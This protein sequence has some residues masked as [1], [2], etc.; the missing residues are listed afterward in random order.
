MKSTKFYQEHSVLRIFL[1]YFKAHR[2]LFALDMACALLVS[3]IDVAFPLVTRR[4][5][6]DLLPNGLYRAFFIVLAVLVAAF[7]L[8]AGLYYIVTYWGHLF[9]VRVEADIRGD[10]FHQMQRLGFDFYD[11]SRTGQLMS[12]LTTDLFD[13]TELAHHGPE[14]LLISFVTIGGALIAMFCICWQ[15]ALVVAIVLPLFLGILMHERGRMMRVSAEVKAR[16]AEIN[17][18]IESSLSGIRTARAFA[19]EHLESEKFTAGNRKYVQ[20]RGQFY[21][22]MG[23]FMTAMECLASVLM[24]AVIGA[25]GFLIM[26]GK[27]DLVDL[28]TF[29][30]FITA[31]INPVRKLA[32]LSELFAAGFAGLKRFAEVMRMEPS[33]RDKEDAAALEN[34]RGEIEARDVCFSYHPDE[35][36]LRDLSFRAAPGEH[37]GIVGLSGGGKSTLCQLILRF[38]DV[39]SGAILVDGRDVR[40]ITQDSLH[41]AVGIVQQDVFLFASTVGDNIRYGRPDATDAEVMEAAK[42]AEIFD[43]IDQMPQGFDTYVGE[44]GVRLSGGQKQRIA[45]ARMFLKN[46]AVLILDEAT[47]ALDSLTEAKVQAA[48]RALSQGRTT[49]TI[50]HRLSTIRDCDRIIVIQDGRIAETGSHEELLEKGGVYAGLYRMQES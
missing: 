4:V 41:R 19:N 20:A 22:A 37:I 11:S 9:G 10:L 17:E 16:T 24:V 38:Y 25:G 14:N 7:V 34:V 40:D 5:L 28:L 26:R 35:P 33:I 27:L 23:R 39:D 47:S 18:G 46:P 29:N 3:A 30:L 49:L 15:L 43:D 48:F 50:A 8:R 45:I 13:V 6:Y 21:V 36:V 31:F 42:R 32:T 2:G 1:S 12:R 44:R